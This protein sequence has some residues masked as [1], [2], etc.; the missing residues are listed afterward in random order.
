MIV[1]KRGGLT[2]TKGNSGVTF[3]VRRATEIGAIQ[4]V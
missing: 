3:P 2:E 4:E 1:A